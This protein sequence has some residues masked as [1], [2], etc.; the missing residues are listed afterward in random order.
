[1][2]TDPHKTHTHAHTH[3]CIQRQPF[4]PSPDVTPAC[5]RPVLRKKICMR[6]PLPPTQ[7]RGR[8]RSMTRCSWVSLWPLTPLALFCAGSFGDCGE[9]CFECFKRVAAPRAAAPPTPRRR[10]I[11]HDDTAGL[12]V[13]PSP[14]SVCRCTAGAGAATA[15]ARRDFGNQ[16]FIHCGRGRPGHLADWCCT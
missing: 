1:M 16:R 11:N 2:N 4:L 14:C 10:G 8:S 9:L 3:I 13:R 7:K 5:T 6:D 12:R 15:R